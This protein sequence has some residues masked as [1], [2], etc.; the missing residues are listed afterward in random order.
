MYTF[1]LYVYNWLSDSISLYNVNSVNTQLELDHHI[2]VCF[3]VSPYVHF[4]IKKVGAGLIRE[5]RLLKR[6]ILD[7]VPIKGRLQVE[8]TRVIPGTLNTK[9]NFDAQTK[10]KDMKCSPIRTFEIKHKQRSFA[11]LFISLPRASSLF[12]LRNSRPQSPSFEFPQNCNT[13]FLQ[14]RRFPSYAAL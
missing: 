9:C 1:I 8:E 11:F 12:C 5:Q 4:I 13:K 10:T 6:S 7:T 3:S 14:N 2:L